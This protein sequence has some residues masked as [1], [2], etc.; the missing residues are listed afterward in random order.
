MNYDL[1]SLGA[2]IIFLVACTRLYTSLC[3]SV[4]PS[5]GPSVITSRFW[6][7]RAKRRA[8]FSY[9]PYP[10][11][12]LPLPSYHTAPSHPHAT[13]AAV[14]TAL[15]PQCGQAQ[16]YYD[17]MLLLYFVQV[18]IFLYVPSQAGSGDASLRGKN[19]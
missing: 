1:G 17:V 4:G 13:D 5:V 10:A 14:Y 15:F 7:F 3:R 9:C 12:I 16:C 8:D 2:N 11:T 18:F 6:A 19:A